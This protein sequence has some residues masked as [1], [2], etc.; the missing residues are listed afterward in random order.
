MAV[1]PKGSKSTVKMLIKDDGTIAG[2][3]LSIEIFNY[4]DPSVNIEAYKKDGEQ[5]KKGEVIM[6]VSGK[7]QSLLGAERLVLN[8]VQRMSGIATHTR[9]LVQLLKGTKA[10]LLD[11][12]K[13]TPNFRIIEK[14]A[15]AIGGGTNH[16]LGL[17]DMIMLKDNHI[18]FAGGIAKAITAARKYL[19]K[20]NKQLRIEIETRSLDEVK[21]VLNTGSVDI[22]MLD[23]MMPSTMR[24]A[25]KLIDGKYKIEASGGIT[26]KNIREVA[27]CGVDYISVGALT[28]SVKSLDISLK[29]M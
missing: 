24:E 5:V 8:C 9:Q 10:Q 25:V 13:T 21:E 2:I 6:L 1:I 7:T 22:I 28:H 19:D 12:R 16:R 26:E 18:D 15:V 4:L 20:E 27:E 14:W 17:Y 29:A 11:T 3:N 23:N